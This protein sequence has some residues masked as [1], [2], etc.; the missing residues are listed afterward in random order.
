MTMPSERRDGRTDLACLVHNS[1]L[2][3]HERD[4]ARDLVE[5]GTDEA[6]AEKASWLWRQLDIR[7]AAF[8]MSR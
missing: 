2:Y 1:W 4:E 3:Q 8:E 6:C 5:H 7:R